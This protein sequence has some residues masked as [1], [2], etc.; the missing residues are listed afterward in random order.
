MFDYYLLRLRIYQCVKFDSVPLSS[1]WRRALLSYTRFMSIMPV[2]SATPRLFGLALQSRARVSAW[3]SNTR[4]KQK[5]GRKV[6]NID[7]GA[8]VIDC[9]ARYSS[10]IAICA[11]PTCIRLP[12][13][14][15]PVGILPWRLVRKKATMV[16]LPDGEKN[17]RYYDSMNDNARLIMSEFRGFDN[18]TRKRVLNKLKTIHAI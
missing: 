2:Y 10:R 12:R 17:W 18:G 4:R 15:V 1:A 5:A 7:D 8:A 11:Y 9:K 16:W 14:G 6:W 13:Y 3:S